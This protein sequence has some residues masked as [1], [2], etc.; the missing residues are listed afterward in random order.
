MGDTSK[1]DEML[2]VLYEKVFETKGKVQALTGLNGESNNRLRQVAI[3][4]N[5][6]LSELIDIR[7][8][9]IRRE[10]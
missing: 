1:S 6:L 2:T 3:A 10:G 4:E 9:Q 8:E 5:K 7:T